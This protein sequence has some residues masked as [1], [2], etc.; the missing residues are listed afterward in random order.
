MLNKAKD[1]F[2]SKLWN[3]TYYNIDTASTA[4]DRNMADQLAGEWY[5]KACG[6]PA[7]VPEAHARSAFQAIYDNAMSAQKV[8]VT[9]PPTAFSWL[10]G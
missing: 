10:C 6:L 9:L 2:E 8:K 7:V 4:A 3:G 5:A 1:S